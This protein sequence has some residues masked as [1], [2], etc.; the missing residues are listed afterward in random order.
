MEIAKDLL[1]DTALSVQD[2]ALQVGI[3]DAGYFA[4]LFKR[5]VGMSPIG[6]RKALKEN[7]DA[8]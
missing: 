8:S 3:N 1:K 6:Y 4:V 2:I 5:Q 7:A